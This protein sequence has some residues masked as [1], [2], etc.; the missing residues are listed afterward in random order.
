MSIH[1]SEK[2]KLKKIAKRQKVEKFN[3]IQNDKI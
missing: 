2:L 3:L 1:K